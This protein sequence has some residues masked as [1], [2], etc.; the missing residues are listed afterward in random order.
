VP[1]AP[2]I[3]LPRPAII[4]ALGALVLL[5]TF[6]I[7]QNKTATTS[8]P[9]P[10][11]STPA[12]TTTTT[13]APVT[14][15]K[16]KKP[17]EPLVKPGQGLPADMARALD[18][19]QVVVLFLYEPAG[20]DDQATRAAVNAVR[21]AG[22]GVRLFTDTVSHISNYRR[23]VGTLGISQSPAMVVIDKQRRAQVFQ[24]FLDAGTIRQT[25][26]DAL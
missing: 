4:A 20:A 25:V 7:T 22:A 10:A 13:T 23:I 14:T 3:E 21:G 17:P 9:A 12:T 18:R 15:V 19:H 16:P 5:V 6:V 11:A 8:A 2:R 26:R 24:G 1:N